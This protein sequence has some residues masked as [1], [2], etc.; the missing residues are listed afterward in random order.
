MAHELRTPMTSIMG[1]TDL[2]MSDTVGVVGEMQLNFLQRVKANIERMGVMLN[3]LIGV[4]AIDTGQ[5]RVE[6]EPVDVRQLIE[7][8]ING[9]QAQLEEKKL[10]LKLKQ[11]KSFPTL[12]ADP[13][14]VRQIMVNLLANACK[15]SREGGVIYIRAQV[16]EAAKEGLEVAAPFLLVSVTDSGNGIA[17]EDLPRVFDRFYKA[18]H[19]LITGLGETD[20]GL[21]VVKTMVEAH[22]GRVWVESK[23]GEGSTFSFALPLIQS[24]VTSGAI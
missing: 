22:Q 10:T 1:Y 20:V 5:L 6:M 17:P 3:N 14:C 12:Y 9:A 19:P 4:T 11:P 13:E 15:A 21:A 16:H 18:D 23:V 24:E 2:L 7:E 8:T